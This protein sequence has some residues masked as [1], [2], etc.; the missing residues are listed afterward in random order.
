MLMRRK[1]E[2]GGE[3]GEEE[4]R[5]EGEKM[6]PGTLYYIPDNDLLERFFH[7]YLQL[8]F[9]YINPFFLSIGSTIGSLP[10][11]LRNASPGSTLFPV[12]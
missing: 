5:Q 3:G 4:G 6:F 7:L 10:L 2:E 1:E 12:L 8:H 11:N 9:F